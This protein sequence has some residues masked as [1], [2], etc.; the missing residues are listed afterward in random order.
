MLLAGSPAGNTHM[1]SQRR[2]VI[3]GG[4]VTGLVAAFEVQRLM[5]AQGQQIHIDLFEGAPRLGGRLFTER[6][7]SF[8]VEAGPDTFLM[9][10]PAG[11]RLCSELGLDDQLV[12]TRQETR[13]SFILRDGVLTAL[14][15]GMSGLVPRRVRDLLGSP[16]LSKR[17]S[18]R[19]CLE[20]FVR[21]R[22]NGRE[23]SIREFATRRYGSEMAERIVEPL[24]SGIYAGDGR[25]LSAAAA[26]PQLY[27]MEKKFGSVSRGLRA[28]TNGSNGKTAVSP[29]VSLAEGMG[30]LIDRLES[31]LCN[32]NVHR[33]TPV[34]AVHKRGAQFQ[35]DVGSD[36]VVAEAVVLA[37]PSY[38][39][40]EM[41]RSW[42]PAVSDELNAIR[43]VSSVIV[44]IGF[45]PAPANVPRHGHGYIVPRGNGTEITACTWTTLK[46]PHRS[47]DGSFLLRVFMGRDGA[48]TAATRPDEQL[49]SMAKDEIKRTL[50][51]DA[52]PA[53]VRIS[54]HVRAMPQY[55]LGHLDRLERIDKML[56]SEQGLFV[57]GCSYGGVGI[58]DCIASGRRAGVQAFHSCELTE[59]R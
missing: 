26:I 38:H 55:A 11:M 37:T 59:A 42:L 27:E 3:V 56:S 9:S 48:E 33:S 23:E 53:M 14:P 44:S 51:I 2:V 57:A 15:E 39:S 12:P 40:A 34:Q 46:L 31:R 35:I 21:S 7:G 1:S 50:G 43:F 47:T 10:K 19:A 32:V 49:V 24:L 41:L 16:L 8:L 22:A 13:Q 28:R 17:G 30:S 45:A 58:P 20:R 4:G 5:H 25:K 54:R 52:T 29:F 6:I 36:S 18:V